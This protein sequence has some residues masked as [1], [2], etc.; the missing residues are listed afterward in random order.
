MNC[1]LLRGNGGFLARQ[2]HALYRVP[3]SFVF[4][5]FNDPYYVCHVVLLTM[6][7]LCDNTMINT[8]RINNEWHVIKINFILR[9]LS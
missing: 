4:Q 8:D 2:R 9:W 7:I 3:S 5:L 6:V 1:Y